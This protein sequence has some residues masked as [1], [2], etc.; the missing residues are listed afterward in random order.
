MESGWRQQL[1]AAT[2]ALLTTKEEAV[3][4]FARRD[5]ACEEVGPL[6]FVR[7]LPEPL[8]ILRKQRTDGSWRGPPGKGQTYPQDHAHLVA[9]FKAFRNLVEKYGFTSA[10]GPIARAAE[11]LFTFQ[12]GEGDIRGFIGNQ[13]ATYYTGYVLA[14]LM[15]AGYTQDPRIERGMQWL[16]RMRQHDGGW[17]VPILT[18]HFD[19]KTM[20]RLTSSYA[21]PVEPD[22]AQPSSHNWTDMVLRA[23]SIHPDYSRSDAATI[24]GMLLKSRFFRPDV[25][26]SYRAASYWTRFLFWWPNLLTAL[27]SLLLLGFPA[28][29]PDIARGLLWFFG[30]QQS[31]GLWRCE[32]GRGDRAEN[33]R[34]ASERAWISLRICRML[35]GYLV[36]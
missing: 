24:A 14:L 25:Y 20:Y 26:S 13:Y 16:L 5:L 11:Y 27:E 30:N 3:T 34:E 17:T 19:G 32:Y 2:A 6:D 23:F 35:K 8:R 28:D 7:D 1:R 31:D 18:H 33:S 12:T 15:R 4:Y 21:E 10:S 9:T 22:I 36:L 29:D